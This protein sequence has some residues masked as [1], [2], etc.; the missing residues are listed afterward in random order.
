MD[1]KY[2]DSSIDLGNLKL[3]DSDCINEF[4]LKNNNT[5]IL[6]AID[7][8]NNDSKFL[9]IHGFLGTGKRQFINYV[10]EYLD[11]DVIK[12]EY[13]CKSSTV[14]DDVLLSFINTIEKNSMSKVVNLNAKV[15]TLQVKLNQYIS[16]IK[17]PFIIIIHS[18]DDIA[19]ENRKHIVDFFEQTLQFDNVKFITSTRAMI[20]N[21]FNNIKTDKKIFLKALNKELFKEFTNSFNIK[22]TENALDNFYKYSRGYYYYT[23]LTLKIIQ[24]M[25][26]SLNDFLSKFTNSGINFDSYLGIT[27]I[28]LIPSTIRNFFWFLRTMRH[29]ISLNALA[30]LEL[31]DEFSIEYLKNNLM[32]FQ[33]G[34]NIYVQDYFQ[35]NIDIS[36]PQ[37]TEIK[38]HKYI[39]SIYEGQLKEPLQTREITISRQAMR[40]EIEY[41]NKKIQELK[42]NKAE[43]QTQ[44][45]TIST[46]KEEAKHPEL[47]QSLEEK[48][49]QAHLLAEEKRNTD[50]ITL[51][52]E[53]AD[54]NK[55]NTHTLT[56][57]RLELAR[58]YKRIEHYTNSQ[59][60]YELVENFYKKNKEVINL[61]Y[62]NYELTEL[63][64]AMYKIDKAIDTIK[65]VIYSV[66]T[67][68]S[69]LVAACTLLGNI[70]SETNSAQE[71][72]NYY[73]KALESIDEHTDDKTKAELYFKF[74]LANDDRHNEKGAF[75]FY[76]K[77]ISIS[78]NTPYKA[79]S[80]SNMG[81]CYLE[82]ENYSDAKDCFKKAYEIEKAN[83][84]YDGIYY[85]ALNLAKIL[86]Q[87]QNP[88]TLNF[89]LEAKQSAEFINEDFYILEATLALGDYYYNNASFYKKALTE[90]FKAKKIA[91][92]LNDSSNII[93]IDARIK[94]MELRM[95]PTEFGEIKN[96]YE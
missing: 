69:L 66:D 47:P 3:H 59:H 61:N 12:L 62:L 96:K 57:I 50:A 40:A 16:A 22:Y 9:Y 74:A 26:I 81:S 24:A 44:D 51:Y 14:C 87:E 28:N 48:L 39:I 17:K 88:D 21:D 8:L 27:Y 1:Y 63:Y 65:K 5:E 64:F 38:L 92:T 56:N 78:E 30:T 77:C 23:A 19:D 53:I 15:T 42:N 55:I 67:P 6:K 79:L 76:S 2:L 82:N 41:H 4:L 75:E 32:I 85:N 10:C 35:Q 80:L 68:Q 11:K 94:D 91:Q 45:N 58:L 90:Y 71:A 13:Y 20:T 18:F 60:Y 93:K 73:Q 72:Y 34:E 89:L 46:K 54:S 33:A 95:N 36:I 25:K 29:G 49:K 52:L 37:K 86:Q 31:Y 7:F 83:N 70:Y 84:N 43:K